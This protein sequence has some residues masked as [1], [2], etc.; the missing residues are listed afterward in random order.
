MTKDEFKTIVKG[1]KAVYTDPKFIPDQY[2]FDMWYGLLK[3]MSY[4]ECAKSTQVYMMSE[5]FP[6]VP[7]DIRGMLVKAQATEEMNG[8]QAW[9]L[10]Y[11]AICNSS[12]NADSEFAK[13][14]EV[15]Q[16]AVGSPDS[17]RAMATNNSFN[18]DVEKSH[19]I[20]I[21][22]TELK[23]SHE[24]AKLPGRLRTALGTN[25][26]LMIGAYND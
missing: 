11:K 3:D 22:D 10:V 15:V 2:A 21:Y 8:A 9:T 18:E 23:R 6:P 12:Y 4:E 16:R 25:N 26:N 17:L 19:F 1:L 14:P 24:N 20:R 5:K 7:S 13:L